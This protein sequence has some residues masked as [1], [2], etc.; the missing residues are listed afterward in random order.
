MLKQLALMTLLTVP[1][2]PAAMAQDDV[3][4]MPSCPHCGMDREKF[5]TSRMVVEYDD[6]SAV[7]TCS[8]RCAALDLA[9]SLDKTPKAVKVADMTSKKLVDADKAFWVVS[10]GKPGV[11]TRNAKWAFA[12]KAEAEAWAK[13]NSGTVVSFDEAMRS[14]YL[15]MH[16]DN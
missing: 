9:V 10:A 1:L 13:Q 5:A 2:A 3:A 11:M 15:D 4:A 7:G 16:E 12:D 6:A 14:S 8:I